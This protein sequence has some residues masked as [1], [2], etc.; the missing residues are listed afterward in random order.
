M[1]MLAYWC[2]PFPPNFFATRHLSEFG[3]LFRHGDPS[4]TE[5]PA[6]TFSRLHVVCADG[7]GVRNGSPMV[8]HERWQ[9]DGS[10]PELYQR[11]LVPAITSLWAAELVEQARPRPDE[12]VLDVACGAGVATHLAAQKMAR[13]RLVGLDLTVECWPSLDLCRRQACRSNGLK[14]ARSTCPFPT[15][16]LISSSASSAFSSFR[17]SRAPSAK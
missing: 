12:S 7:Q 10:A 5:D 4:D 16:V 6:Q 9:L 14:P 3:Q 2:Q 13:G 15:A 17:I 11:Y 1:P 8:D